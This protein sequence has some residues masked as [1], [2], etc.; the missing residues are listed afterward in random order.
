MTMATRQR[1]RLLGDGK[2][3]ADVCRE[4]LALPAPACVTWL[5]RGAR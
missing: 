1:D 5:M 4:T 3:V 2:R